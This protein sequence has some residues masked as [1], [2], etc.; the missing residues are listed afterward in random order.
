MSEATIW[1]DRINEPG[2]KRLIFEGLL[3][4]QE[5]LR[6]QAQTMW[7]STRLVCWL[8]HVVFGAVFPQEAGRLRGPDL[9]V[10][11]EF[12]PNG[13]HSGSPYE[14]VLGDMS[15][16]DGYISRLQVQL[17]EAVQAMNLELR[18]A[19]KVGGWY[20]AKVVAIHPFVDGNGRVS[21]LCL[22][23]FAHR[24][25]LKEFQVQGDKEGRYIQVLDWFISRKDAEP[26]TDY[27][28][29]RMLPS[30]SQAT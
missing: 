26:L 14:R 21:R 2:V 12:G 9:P 17:D 3:K 13:V 1:N 30:A 15:E 25:G 7:M 11:V 22:N 27:L 28:A 23:Y 10:N 29:R 18:D 8:H 16:L 20:H 19:V 4:A 5:A 6:E 24:Y